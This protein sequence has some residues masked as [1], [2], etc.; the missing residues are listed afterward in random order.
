[1]TTSLRGKLFCSL[2]MHSMIL[3]HTLKAHHASLYDVMKQIS[4]CYDI[5]LSPMC[6]P[7][8]R[9]GNELSLFYIQSF[10]WLLFPVKVQSSAIWRTVDPKKKTRRKIKKICEKYNI[11]WKMKLKMKESIRYL[12][13]LI[14]VYFSEIWPSRLISLCS[15]TSLSWV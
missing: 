6:N 1:M 15:V 14:E 13:V 4:M 2:L 11:T 9:T 12:T 3:Y 10:R 7:E 5:L 8:T